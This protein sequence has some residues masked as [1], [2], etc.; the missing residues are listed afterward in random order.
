MLRPHVDLLPRWILLICLLILVFSGGRILPSCA[1]IGAPTGGARDTIPPQI[2]GEEPPN[3]SVAFVDGEKAFSFSGNRIEIEFD[4]YIVLRDALNQIYISPPTEED[5]KTELRGKTLRIELPDSLEPFTTYTINFGKSI[6]DLTEGN[7]Q[8]RYK[9]VFSTGAFIDS[10]YVTG[11]VND[12]F[13]NE[14]VKDLPVVLY[15]IDSVDQPIDSLPL[16]ERPSYYAVSGEDGS[17][18]IDYVKSGSFLVFAFEDKNSDFLYNPGIERFAFHA[19]LVSSDSLPEVDLRTSTEKRPPQ[20]RQGLHPK[21]GRISFPFSGEVD[22]ISVEGPVPADTAFRESVLRSS[23][24]RDTIHLFFN[25]FSRDSLQFYLTIN[26]TV[27][28]T[29]LVL[30][31]SYDPPKPAYR[32]SATPFLHPG[33]SLFLFGERP[34]RLVKPDLT[35]FRE[36]DTLGMRPGQV[37]E[38]LF[39]HDLAIRYEEKSSSKLVIYPNQI[40][41]LGGIMN[42]DTLTFEWKT[43]NDEDYAEL[44]LQVDTDWEAPFVFEL[45]RDGREVFERYSFTSDWKYRLTHI[46]AGRYNARLLEDLDGNGQWTPGSWFDRRQPERY[47]FYEEAITVKANWEL[48]TVWKVREQAFHQHD[49]SDSTHTHDGFED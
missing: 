31:R 45:L 35:I 30:M 29:A 33:D 2:V 24:N 23:S 19:G 3:L 25:N 20:L 5:L 37:D 11:I 34:F 17:F 43:Q 41:A 7:I 6:T 32:L 21:W 14:T 38:Y 9:Y 12:G 28:D 16:L 39:K 49:A 42:E 44:I 10:L 47:F 48:E 15:E 40:E 1:M 22:R 4:E 18:R 8:K 27:L 26:D 13:L 46:E 36:S